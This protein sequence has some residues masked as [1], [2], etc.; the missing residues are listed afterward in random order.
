MWAWVGRREAGSGRGGL[1]TAGT[2]LGRL[3][4]RGI[5]D[6]MLAR[7]E[8]RDVGGAKIDRD[9][10]RLRVRVWGY[11]LW[12]CVCG[13]GVRACATVHEKRREEERSGTSKAPKSF[14][15]T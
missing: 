11:V 13:W 6:A 15:V 14:S 4:L 2:S 3:E 7:Q 8:L 1:D 10:S 12:V 5:D 9:D